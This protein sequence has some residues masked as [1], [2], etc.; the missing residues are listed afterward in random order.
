[1]VPTA[2]IKLVTMLTLTYHKS[3]PFK[4][5]GLINFMVHNHQG[6]NQNYK[7]IKSIDIWMCKLSQV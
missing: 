7:S 4:P 1:M 5:S 3:P 6:L 2:V